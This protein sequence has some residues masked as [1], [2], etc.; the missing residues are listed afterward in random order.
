M[1]KYRIK[2]EFA[3]KGSVSYVIVVKNILVV[4]R[5]ILQKR[6]DKE[7]LASRH[8]TIVE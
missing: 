3:K 8:T 5:H 1:K 7:R 2:L 4:I 6:C